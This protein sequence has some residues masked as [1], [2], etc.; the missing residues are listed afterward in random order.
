LEVGIRESNDYFPILT[1]TLDSLLPN[2]PHSR[3]PIFPESTFLTFPKF[4]ERV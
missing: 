4:A 2:Y 3:L 1:P